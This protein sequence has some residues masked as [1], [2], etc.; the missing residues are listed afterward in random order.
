MLTYVCTVLMLVWH[1]VVTAELFV[2]DR[3]KEGRKEFVA[4]K[5]LCMFFCAERHHLGPE[6]AMKS[7]LCSS[8]SRCL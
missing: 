3:R 4:M 2:R 6:R 7:F 1:L 8:L 5:T